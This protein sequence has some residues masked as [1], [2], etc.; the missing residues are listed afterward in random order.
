MGF[1]KNTRLA[2]KKFSKAAKINLILLVYRV[3][4]THITFVDPRKA[5]TE[6]SNNYTQS[7]AV[8]SLI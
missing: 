7:F 2:A 4:K 1:S 8:Q 5:V 6:S 3:A